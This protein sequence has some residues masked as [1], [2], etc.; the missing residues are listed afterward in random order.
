M[1]AVVPSS[2]ARRTA[3]AVAATLA[4]PAVWLARAAWG[5]PTALGASQREVQAYAAGSPHFSEGRFHNRVSTPARPPASAC[6]MRATSTPAAS[7]KAV[8]S[9]TA[10]KFS[11]QST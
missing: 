9:A 5:L 11:P 1:L 8:A 7:A 6:G 10:R 4:G 3:L 2:A